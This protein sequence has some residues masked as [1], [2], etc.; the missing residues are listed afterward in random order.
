FSQPGIVTIPLGFIVLIA[1]SLA[2]RGRMESD[3]VD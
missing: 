1:V 3:K 2:T